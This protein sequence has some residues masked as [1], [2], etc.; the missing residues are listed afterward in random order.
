VTPAPSP[1]AL[2][3]TDTVFV[4]V[5]GVTRELPADG[6]NRDLLTVLRDSLGVMA[7]KEGCGTG[8]CGA[9]TVLLDG[10]PVN[11]CTMLA[12]DAAGCDLQTAAGV[13][14]GPG[15]DVAHC[16]VAAGG[17]QCGFCSPGFLVSITALLARHPDVDDEAA[18]LALAG[19]LC[20]CTGYGRILA[21]VEMVQRQRGSR[22]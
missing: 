18:R 21:A 14:A 22:P 15:A 19:N 17:V 10:Q 2:P 6:E 13:A 12:G 20:R 5:D 3:V 4:T 8:V 9:C 1:T 16:L 7:P 11:S